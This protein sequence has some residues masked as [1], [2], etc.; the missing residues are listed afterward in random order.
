MLGLSAN[1]SNKLKIEIL[2]ILTYRNKRTRRIFYNE[3]LRIK[4]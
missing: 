1:R 3:L 2:S 4:N